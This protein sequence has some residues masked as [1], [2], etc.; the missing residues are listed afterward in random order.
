MT[1]TYCYAGFSW[2]VFHNNRFVGYVVAMSGTDAYR[3]AQDKY[4]KYVWVER[5]GGY[6]HGHS[7]CLGGG[8]V[9]S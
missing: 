4:G 5:V 8:W 7:G 6:S 3:K 2:R 1:D 9:A